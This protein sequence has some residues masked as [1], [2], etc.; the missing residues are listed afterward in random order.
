MLKSTEMWSKVSNIL[1]CLLLRAIRGVNIV[2][3]AAIVLFLSKTIF[4]IDI[5]LFL[6]GVGIFWSASS[7]TDVDVVSSLSRK[8]VSLNW[9]ASLVLLG[10]FSWL[11]YHHRLQ[12]CGNIEEILQKNGRKD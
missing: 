11:L 9:G 5:M 3:F 8:I 1:D 7:G 10:V 12:L 4:G 2:I 6:V